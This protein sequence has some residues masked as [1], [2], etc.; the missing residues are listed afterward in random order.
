MASL[1]HRSQSPVLMP[2]PTTNP[3]KLDMPQDPTLRNQSKT[4]LNRWK[5]IDSCIVGYDIGCRIITWRSWIP[6]RD[7]R[8]WDRRHEVIVLIGGSQKHPS[9]CRL[10]PQIGRLPIK[11]TPATT[12]SSRQSPKSSQETWCNN[13]NS[14]QPPRLSILD[15][16]RSVCTNPYGHLDTT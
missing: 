13:P 10:R 16:W 5:N 9:P 4:H 8:R 11:L 14:L 12:I 1:E 2:N 6:L 7:H 15:G 3:K